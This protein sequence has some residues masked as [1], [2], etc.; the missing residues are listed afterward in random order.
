MEARKSFN[1]KDP[2][3]CIS[4]FSFGKLHTDVDAIFIKT[5]TK[6]NTFNIALA[7]KV[8]HS[9]ILKTIFF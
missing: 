1:S 9:L 2:A 5:K 4:I 8:F 3:C 7:K 6:I